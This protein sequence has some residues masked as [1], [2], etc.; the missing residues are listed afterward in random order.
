MGGLMAAFLDI[1]VAAAMMISVTARVVVVDATR[2]EVATVVAKA[3]F[4]VKHICGVQLVLESKPLL[5][6]I[7]APLSRSCVF[8]SR[9]VRK[10][11]PRAPYVLCFAIILYCQQGR[12]ASRW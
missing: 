11:T 1:K 5:I 2:A 9:R 6:H 8:L 4:E 3:C 7:L 10:N 12:R